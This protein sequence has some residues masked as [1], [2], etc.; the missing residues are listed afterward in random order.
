MKNEKL[1][2]CAAVCATALCAST[3]SGQSLSYLGS[4]GTNWVAY[5]GAS[6]V[7]VLV[8]TSPGAITDA[9]SAGSSFG[10]STVPSAGFSGLW[11]AGDTYRLDLDAVIGNA[12][13]FRIEFSNV[14]RNGGLQYVFINGPAIGADRVEVNSFG[15]TAGLSLYTGNVGGAAATGAQRLFGDI[16]FTVQP[17]LTTAAVS[18]SLSDASGVIWSASGVTAPLQGLGPAGGTLFPAVNVSSGGSATAINNMTWSYTTVPEPSTGA[19]ALLGLAIAAF[20]RAYR[21]A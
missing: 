17:G 2:W 21:K 19:I 9:T 14:N 7:P 16:T 5:G 6:A 3:A 1:L 10:R 18:G 13:T 8:T 4:F 12:T 15:A 20:R 11:K